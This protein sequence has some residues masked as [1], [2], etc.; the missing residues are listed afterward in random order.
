MKTEADVQT[1]AEI[2]FGGAR[3]LAD[4]AGALFWPEERILVVADLHLEKGSSYARFRSHLPPHDTRATLA[5]LAS[6]VDL[7]APKTVVALGDSVHDRRAW[8][9]LE[10]EDTNAIR[11]LTSQVE[12][13][14]WVTGNH[15]PDPPQNVDGSSVSELS[16][17]KI[18]F[19]HI[20]GGPLSKGQTEIAGHLH[21]AARVLGRG[22]STRRPAFATDGNRMIL[23]AFGAY[24]GGL[25]LSSGAFRD[26][27]DPTVFRA[28]VCG[29]SRVFA[30][31]GSSVLG[32][33]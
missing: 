29:R 22:G 7:Y 33:R 32:W 18:A 30:V 17:G 9:R 10:G 26:L 2:S 15:D 14:I 13:W 8:E 25:C 20:P 27:F 24:A 12:H 28:Y 21:P 31:P 4:R 19:R 16:V 23:P 3:F 5:M 1:H 11:T 6:L